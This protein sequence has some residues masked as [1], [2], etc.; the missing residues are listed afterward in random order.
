MSGVVH[1]GGTGSW[2]VS[3]GTYE[4][5]IARLERLLISRGEGH[6]GGMVTRAMPPYLMYL[7]LADLEADDF[8]KVQ[9][10]LVEVREALLREGPDGYGGTPEVFP[11]VM[12]NATDLTDLMEKD[13]RTAHGW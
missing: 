7:E 5:V 10:A 13:P 11:A 3:S 8:R 4:Q 12:K 9:Q 2:I 1:T 6:L